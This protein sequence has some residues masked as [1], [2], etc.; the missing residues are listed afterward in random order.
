MTDI[1]IIGGGTAGMSAAIYALRAGKSVLI[2]EKEAFGGQIIYSHRVENYPG[3]SRISGNDF[4]SAL[5]D[6]ATDLGAEV[7]LEKA[8]KIIDLGKTKKVI[9][10]DG[11]HECKSVIIASGVKSR[12]LG[13]KGEEDLTGS[14]VSYCAVCDGAFYKDEDVAVIGGG[15]TALQDAVWLSGYCSKVYVIHRRDE[16]RGENSLVN[17]LKAKDNVEFILSHVVEEIE[18]TDSVIGIK[19]KSTVTGEIS[20]LDVKGVFVAVGQVPDNRAFEDTAELDGQGFIASDE[21]CMTKTAGVFT[22]GDCRTKKVRQLTTAAADGATAALA[23]CDYIDR[24]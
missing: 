14:G 17:A 24:L 23:A 21:S 20:R 6:Q 2:L 4:A 9:T 1:I 11:E 16:F 10:D 8:E 5:F 12:K 19:I 3:I 7:S 22:A 18:G 13:A 15:N